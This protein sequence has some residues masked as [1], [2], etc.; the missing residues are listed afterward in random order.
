M[1]VVSPVA[2]AK[3]V[4]HSD[5]SSVLSL[6]LQI[7]QRVGVCSAQ[8]HCEVL[9]VSVTTN[10]FGVLV[11]LCGRGLK[12]VP[13]VVVVLLKLVVKVFVVFVVVAVVVFVVVAVVV[14]VVIAVG[15]VLIGLVVEE[16]IGPI[17]VVMIGL[18]VEEGIGPIKVVSSFCSGVLLFVCLAVV[19]AVERRKFCVVSMVEVVV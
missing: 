12:R 10:R 16:G 13:V 5:G 8:S 14:F 9:A 17:K 11:A 6:R 1:E 18:V 19:V 15:V 3:H 2:V 7:L 4:G